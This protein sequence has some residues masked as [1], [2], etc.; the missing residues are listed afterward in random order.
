MHA[1]ASSAVSTPSATV[2]TSSSRAAATSEATSRCR[3]MGAVVEAGDEA[4]VEL[5]VV[6]RRLG[7]L[8]EARLA[9]PE[10]VVGQRRR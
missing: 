5:Q 4:A 7:Q 2:F 8:E 9:G 1:A 6:G 3:E 10:V